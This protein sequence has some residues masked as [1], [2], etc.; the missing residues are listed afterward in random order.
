[1]HSGP[2]A[3]YRSLRLTHQIKQFLAIRNFLMARIQLKNGQRPGPIEEA[4]VRDFQRMHKEGNKYIMHVPR[5]KTTRLGPAPLTTSEN[6][7][8]NLDMY[9][10]HVRP[11][12]TAKDEEAIFV[13]KM[14]LVLHQEEAA[15]PSLPRG[16]KSPVNTSPARGFTRWQLQHCTTL[17][18]LK[19]EVTT[20][21][22]V[23]LLNR[24]T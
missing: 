5:H 20:G 22:C 10:H 15:N 13:K 9:L 7:K 18:L 11:F 14:A 16:R 2:F 19:R 1:M 3:I 8:S 24:T 21:L 6:L 23:I 17:I 4:R 12:F